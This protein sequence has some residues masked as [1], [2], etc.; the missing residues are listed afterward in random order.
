MR[1]SDRRQQTKN[2]P[3]HTE[4]PPTWRCDKD[5]ERKARGIYEGGWETL[6]RGSYG[7]HY[8]MLGKLGSE[9]SPQANAATPVSGMS[10]PR[11]R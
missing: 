8:A 3:F 11:A 2:Q 5:K 10:K 4:L 7:D 6:S 1:C 9:G